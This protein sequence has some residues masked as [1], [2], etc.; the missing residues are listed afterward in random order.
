MHVAPLLTEL[1]QT[2]AARRVLF[3]GA[4]DIDALVA[5]ARSLPDGGWLLALEIDAVRVGAARA[6]LDAAGQSRRASVMHGDAFRSLHK[7]AGPFDLAVL[8]PAPT[9]RPAT[10]VSAPPLLARVRLLVPPP[11]P[12]IRVD[13]VAGCLQPITDDSAGHRP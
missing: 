4:G 5:V 2:Y 9:L 7:V 3:V 12:I 8:F 13:T 6:A 1:L 10:P 11:G